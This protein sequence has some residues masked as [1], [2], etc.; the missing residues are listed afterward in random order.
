M[1]SLKRHSRLA[2]VV[3][4]LVVVISSGIIAQSSQ[5]KQVTGQDEE[6]AV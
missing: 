6:F 5:N 4:A 1:S 2:A 3:L